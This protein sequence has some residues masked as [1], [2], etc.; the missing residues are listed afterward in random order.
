MHCTAHADSCA[1]SALK[2]PRKRKSKRVEVFFG[3][4]AGT[5]GPARLRSRCLTEQI[6][7][8]LYAANRDRLARPPIDV[9]RRGHLVQVR[10]DRRSNGLACPRDESGYC[11]RIETIS[12]TFTSRPSMVL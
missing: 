5:R 12:A 11:W 3:R 6:D 2:N 8:Q 7:S 9:A 4:V 1:P 10:A